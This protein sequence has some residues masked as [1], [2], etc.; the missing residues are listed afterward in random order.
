M[1]KLG[2]KPNPIPS[3][4]WKCYVPLNVATQVDVLLLDPFTGAPRKGARSAL[5]TQ[6]LIQWLAHQR[7][8]GDDSGLQE[9]TAEKITGE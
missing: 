1:A 5:I 8:G 7:K 9:K 4:D 6:L 2:R 3:I